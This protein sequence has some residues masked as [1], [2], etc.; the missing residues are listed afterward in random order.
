MRLLLMKLYHIETQIQSNT[1]AI[2]SKREF[3]Q[4]LSEDQ[5]SQY[6]MNVLNRLEIKD[7]AKRELKK[8]TKAKA[9]SHN[10]TIKTENAI[11]SSQREIDEK[12]RRY[13]RGEHF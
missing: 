12:V 2:S 3:L 6:V 9:E 11:K 5:V 4:Q 8:A 1:E 10:N 7:N 13:Q